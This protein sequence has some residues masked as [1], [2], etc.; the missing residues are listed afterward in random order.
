MQRCVLISK[1]EKWHPHLE[2][3]LHI[4]ISSAGAMSE[5]VPVTEKIAEDNEESEIDRQ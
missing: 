1:V 4:R 2:E 5:S 3:L